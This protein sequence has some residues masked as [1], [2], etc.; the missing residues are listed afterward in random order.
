MRPQPYREKGKSSVD[1]NKPYALRLAEKIAPSNLPRGSFPE[2]VRLTTLD[3]HLG[4]AL[5]R[6]NCALHFQINKATGWLDRPSLSGPDL[7]DSIWEGAQR[8]L[9]GG[10]RYQTRILQGERTWW[11][12]APSSP[13][14]TNHY[15]EHYFSRINAAGW[16]PHFRFPF[17]VDF[18]GVDFH[19][20]P[21]R[22]LAFSQVRFEY[23][24]L[25]EADLD[26]SMFIDCV[27]TAA[28]AR[29]SDWTGSRI[30][31]QVR[32]K[33]ANW[34]LESANLEDA[35][36][37]DSVILNAFPE[38]AAIPPHFSGAIFAWV[39]GEPR[40]F[41]ADRQNDHSEPLDL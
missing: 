30:F 5:L 40:R 36:F 4:D 31:E 3:A 41:R 24:R 18:S 35:G 17:Q 9:D 12:F 14:G 32:V 11:A 27:F 16:Y 2:P 21:L 15:L 8:D 1:F 25:T 10:R 33:N 20:A 13:D 28:L 29:K 38:D 22:G 37:E 34:G 23:A 26:A 39:E 19:S 7:A 6:L